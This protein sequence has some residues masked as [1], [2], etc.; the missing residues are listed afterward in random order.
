[1]TTFTE[2]D[3]VLIVSIGN[4]GERSAG[5]AT[6][7]PIHK[8]GRFCLE[9]RGPCQWRADGTQAGERNI[10]HTARLLPLGSEAATKIRAAAKRR[11]RGPRG[12]RP[13]PRAPR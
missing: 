2:G 13:D 10:W 1:M 3:R 9:G 5:T 6:V 8:S 11:G 7:G 12:S 4:L